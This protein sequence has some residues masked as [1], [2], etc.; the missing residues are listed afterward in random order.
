VKL[1]CAFAAAG[2]TV[3][4][5]MHVAPQ[6]KPYWA[7]VMC[8]ATHGVPIGTVMNPLAALPGSLAL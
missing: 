2:L 4:S 3:I 5:T 6:S 8:P 1:V 7:K